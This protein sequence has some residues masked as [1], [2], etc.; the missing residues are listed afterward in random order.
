MHNAIINVC[1]Q[2]SVWAYVF[3]S[4]GCIPQSGIVGSCGHP[5]FNHSLVFL[6][7]SLWI[8]FLVVLL[9]ITLHIHD[10][11]QSTDVILPVLVKYRDL[12]SS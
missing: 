6:S 8:T 12:T 10:L 9:Y 4:L 7:M 5:M 1:V 2:V 3:I 11:S